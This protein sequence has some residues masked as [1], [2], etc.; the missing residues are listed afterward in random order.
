MILALFR[1][2]FAFAAAC[3]VAAAVQV[4]FALAQRGAGTGET[5]AFELI[6]LTATHFAIFSLPF[7]LVVT[8]IAEWQ[9]I[10]S[11]LYYAFAG[12]G[13]AL[14]GFMAQLASESGGPTILNPYAIKAFLTPG[15]AAGFAYW[16]LAGRHAGGE[17]PAPPKPAD[18]A[19]SPAASSIAA[20]PAQAK[21]NESGP[22]PPKPADSEPIDPKP[23]D[24]KPVQSK[25]V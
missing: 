11:W 5:G 4:G 13:I 12:I 25:P 6:L 9:G 22:P 8:A 23:A 19:R 21:P 20:K 7:A 24:L 3:L 16:I 18:A 17:D 10:R 15:F 1:V 2:L 14:A